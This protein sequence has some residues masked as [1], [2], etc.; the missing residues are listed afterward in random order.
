MKKFSLFLL[1]LV[2]T[3]SVYSQE[4]DGTST[5]AGRKTTFIKNGFWDNWF[6]GAGAGA[7]IYFG[8]NDANAKLKNRVTVTPNFQFG[9]WFNPYFG[10][11]IKVA[12]GTN[13]HTFN[14]NA[15]LMTRQKYISAEANFMWNV[16]DYLMSYNASR[17]YNF[18]PY[19]GAGYAYA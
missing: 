13:I 16:T 8:D 4:L 11:R 10:S 19:V 2:V 17:F 9:T 18:I 14:N 12:G 3:T 1:L 5:D 7:N 6:I 15:S